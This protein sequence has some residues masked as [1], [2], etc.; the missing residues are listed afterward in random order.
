MRSLPAD[1][2]A[3]GSDPDRADVHRVLAGDVD[4]FE[5]IVLRWQRPIVNLAYRFCRHPALAEEMA[6]EAFLRA[7]RSL[8]QWRGEG[9]FSTWLFALAT[10]VCRT[11]ARRLRP[12]EVPIEDEGAT[13]DPHDVEQDVSARQRAELVRRMVNALPGKYRD[14]LILFYFMEEDIAA[15]AKS[16][17]VPDGTLKARLHRARALLRKRLAPLMR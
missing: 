17:N 5:H 1:Q 9:A 15:A 10:N 4:A 7:F 13:A 14:A 8:D 16:L 12:L 6:Q 2:R 11:R 3:A